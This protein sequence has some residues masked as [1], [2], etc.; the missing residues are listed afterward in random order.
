VIEQHNRHSGVVRATEV[1]VAPEMVPGGRSRFTRATLGA[2]AAE[3]AVG[4][5][6]RNTLALRSIR[7]GEATGLEPGVTVWIAR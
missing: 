3:R 1:R 2:P 7:K 4:D 6:D 5:H